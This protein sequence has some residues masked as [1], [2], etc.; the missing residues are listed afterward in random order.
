MKTSPRAFGYASTRMEQDF[1]PDKMTIVTGR[2]MEMTSTTVC[3]QEE[4]LGEGSSGKKSS[5]PKG[6]ISELFLKNS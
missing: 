6:T 3:T 4:T 1:F 5:A 2:V